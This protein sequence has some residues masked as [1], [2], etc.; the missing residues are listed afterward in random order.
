ML[1]AHNKLIRK[2][3]SWIHPDVRRAREV[4]DA[5]PEIREGRV[6]SVQ[7]YWKNGT[8]N[9]NKVD[10]DRLF[11]LERLQQEQETFKQRKNHQAHWFTLKVIM[12]YLSIMFLTAIMIFSCIII[13]NSNSYPKSVVAYACTALFVEVLGLLISVWKIVLNPDLS[14]ELKPVTVN[15]IDTT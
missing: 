11:Y 12:G 1:G 15:N 5:A 6:A 9:L 3:S 2:L 7:E 14:T 4:V 10:L 13:F 8:L